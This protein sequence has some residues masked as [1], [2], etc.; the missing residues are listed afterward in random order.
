MREVVRE[1]T[2]HKDKWEEI[3]E[4]SYHPPIL[5]KVRKIKITYF[6]E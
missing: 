1:A 2:I 6:I 3:L 5:D 4:G